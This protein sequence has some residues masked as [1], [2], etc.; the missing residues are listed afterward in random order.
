M[1]MFKTF[2]IESLKYSLRYLRGVGL[3]V[4]NNRY[5]LQRTL[6]GGNLDEGVEVSF[7]IF[8]Y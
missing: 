1:G 5:N 8:C 3:D 2:L 4:S 7:E 6:N